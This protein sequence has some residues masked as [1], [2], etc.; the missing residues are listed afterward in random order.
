MESRNELID[1]LD[2]VDVITINYDFF[3]SRALIV[4]GEEGRET[5][6][7]SREEEEEE[8]REVDLWRRSIQDDMEDVASLSPPGGGA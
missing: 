1:W 6:E 3:V 5:V 4:E 8:G 7:E 2:Q